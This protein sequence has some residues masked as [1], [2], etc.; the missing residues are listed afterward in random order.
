M[1][2]NCV[3]PGSFDPVTLGH[4][5]I[6]TR[7]S[8]LFDTVY[9]TVFRN[10]EKGGMFSHEERFHM[11]RLA[12]AHL[13]NV[14]C[15]TGEGLLARYVQKRDAVLIKGV[16]NATDFDYEMGLSC[17]NRAICAEVDTVL[18]PARQEYLHISSSFARELIRYGH[19]IRAALPPPVCDY[20]ISKVSKENFVSDGKAGY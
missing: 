13:E 5:D 18:I 3:F 15:E 7:A 9:V 20:L 14:I 1:G 17:I 19:D 8:S 16:R 11:L 4:L 6:I 2:R 12:T 10:A